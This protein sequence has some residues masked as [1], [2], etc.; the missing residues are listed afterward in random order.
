MSSWLP[1]SDGCSES[2][3]ATQGGGTEFQ[4]V[5]PA[6]NIGL[7]VILHQ[8]HTDHHQPENGSHCINSPQP[9]GIWWGWGGGG[10]KM[11]YIKT[12]FQTRVKRYN[13]SQTSLHQLK[14]AIEVSKW[15]QWGT[16]LHYWEKN[17]A[18]IVS[19]TKVLIDDF[20]KGKLR[21]HELAFTGRTTVE[22]I[23]SFKFPG[24]HILT[25]PGPS[26]MQQS[27]RKLTGTSVSGS[28]WH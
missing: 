26:T 27:Q 4:S 2:H 9:K 1:G 11:K 21:G 24:L 23:N 6:R 16:C 3:Y 17:L 20:M 13:I 14:V 15:A 18:P 22:R 10:K 7:Q 5:K 25:R 8:I 28:A 12:I 19:K